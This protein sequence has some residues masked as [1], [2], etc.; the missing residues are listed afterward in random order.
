MSA[1][2]NRVSVW[3][4]AVVY[5]LFLSGNLIAGSNAW[6]ATAPGTIISN[7]AQVE[8]RDITGN[9][10]TVQSNKANLAVR[11]P[12]KIEIM[13]YAPAFAGSEWI[14][15]SATE[16][17]DNAGK[18]WSMPA[19]KPLDATSPLE[20]NKPWP[21]MKADKLY[22]NDT[23]FIRLTDLDQNLDPNKEESVVITLRISA[24]DEAETLRLYESGPNT[25]I[26]MGYIKSES[27]G[28]NSNNG[29]LNYTK[30]NGAKVTSSYVD[31]FDGTD[32]TTDL[33]L[34]VD[35]FGVIF[36]S[37]TGVPVNGVTITLLN[38]STGQPAKV[39]GDDGVSAYPSTMV[40]GTPVTDAGGKVYTFSAGEYRFPLVEPGKYRLAVT[41]PAG[42]KFPS[43][44]ATEVLQKLPGGP[45]VLDDTGSR[46]GEFTVIAGPALRFDIP[47][48]PLIS[49]LFVAKSASKQVASVGDFLQYKIT[50]ENTST[51]VNFP[52]VTVTDVLP[53]G[54]RY[55]KGSLQLNGASV[56]DPGISDDGKTLGINVGGLVVN[57]KKTILYV[58]EVSAGVKTGKS[59]NS[60]QA[61]DNAGTTS[62]TATATV[63]VKDAF[64]SDKGF[65]AGNVVA[66]ACSDGT[67]G[68]GTGVE[69]IRIYLEDGTYVL[70]DKNG[71]YHFEG[72]SP[73]TRVV[74]LDVASVPKNYEVVF[75]EKNTRFADNPYSQFADIRGGTLWRADFYLRSV[76]EGNSSSKTDDT[77]VEVT[78]SETKTMPS[79]DNAWLDAADP[80]F[81][82]LWPP[83]GFYPSMPSIKVTVKH[84]PAKTLK[85]YI[86]QQEVD[87]VY[88]DGVMKRKDGKI[89]ISFW[90]AVNLSEG[91]NIL[92]AVEYHQDGTENARIKRIFHYSGTPVK[93]EILLNQSVLIADGKTPPVI[94]VR[95]TDRD[96]HPAGEGVTGEFSVDSP[97]I[98]LKIADDMQKNP[99]TAVQIGASNFIVGDNGMALI[100]LQPTSKTGEAVL[101]LSLENGVHE[102]RVWLN[103]EKR[104]WIL[105]GVADGTLGYGILTEHLEQLGSLSDSVD[106]WDEDG[107]IAFF[108]KGAIK[109]KWLLTMAYESVK[110]W[111]KDTSSLHQTI[112]P[113]TYYTVYG[114]TSQQ[115]YD[116]A[117]SLPLYIKIERDKFYAL[118]GDYETG[119]TVTELS[120]YNRNF[121]GFK[122]EL[123]EDKYGFNV[124]V[125][126]TRQKYVRDEIRGDGTSGLYQLTKKNIVL[127]SESVTI[128]T[129]DRFHS[130]NILTSRKLTRHTDYNIDYEDATLY[131][132]A[133]VSSKDEDFNPVFIVVEYETGDLSDYNYGGRASFTLLD[134]KLETGF[135]YVHDGKAGGKGDLAGIDAVYNL[136]GQTKLKTEAAAM[137]TVLVSGSG[138]LAELYNR[139]DRFEGKF[140]FREQENDF[141]LGQQKGSESRT[142]KFGM[143]FTY[144]LSRFM[145]VS[146]DAYKSYNL[147]TSAVRTVVGIDTNYSAGK[148]DL[149]AGLLFADDDYANGNEDMS[150]QIVLGSNFRLL[151]DRLN[152]R[153]RHNQSIM[154]DDENTDFPTRTTFGLDY[155]LRNNTTLFGEQEFTWSDQKDTESTRLGV[156]VSPWSGS[157]INST[158][159]R[160]FNENGTRVF[161]V[162]GMKQTW[163]VTKKWTI[164]AGLDRSNTLKDNNPPRFNVNVPETSGGT[165][166]TAVSLGA[167][168]LEK[169]WSWTGRV[170]FK[171]SASE[172]KTGIYTGLYAEPKPGLGTSFGLQV[173][174]TDFAT[175]ATKTDGK[176]SLG[177]AYRPELS[178]WIILDR[179]EYIFEKQRN[180]DFNFD[181]WRLVNNFNAHY[182]AGRK[183]RLA[184]LYGAKFVGET[185]DTTEY[186][187][188]TDLI[189]LEPRYD[190][191]KK[192]DVGIR[193]LMLHSWDANQFKYSHDLSLGYNL[194]KNIWLS[195][196]Y[197]WAGFNDR[198]FSRA[199]FT[200]DGPFFKFRLKFDQRSFKDEAKQLAKADLNAQLNPVEEKAPVVAKELI[201][202]EETKPDI[203]SIA[204]PSNAT[205]EKP[206]NLSEKTINDAN[207]LTV[208]DEKPSK[209]KSEKPSKKKKKSKSKKK[210]YSK[211][212]YR[213]KK[214]S[215]GEIKIQLSD[216]KVK[217]K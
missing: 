116:A 143:D 144:R 209:V 196:G 96:G 114:D 54:F 185:I 44:V 16:Y 58:V 140:Y 24:T 148:Y 91:D 111:K 182:K 72:V 141:G 97:Y 53:T 173:F 42:F 207:P 2:K 31:V 108:A 35:P 34:L 73:G 178:R 37:A 193:S 183:M 30:G 128:E 90:R 171:D 150:K 67:V 163:T 138:Y 47:M 92:E 119:L 121:T 215:Y 5:W 151:K 43:T 168:F 75:C 133:S 6:G 124:F 68:K 104:E 19:P 149:L 164:D 195:I 146:A 100:K 50:V 59:A 199:D 12:S 154:G 69:G 203:V 27:G 32:A 13:E 81:E 18:W 200:N 156:K 29:T 145:G 10:V 66:D 82:L 101:K 180:A 62:N 22:G 94:A 211:K 194:A 127:N 65:I 166:F 152:F 172:D 197:N 137:D 179:L 135:T 84:D 26:F 76:N 1:K 170:E 208:N 201:T 86:N 214:L 39:F 77:K 107:R 41:S 192:W 99:L 110:K 155:K 120:R 79:F 25:G 129:R 202:K 126:D 158:V 3:T 93:A 40:S 89:N 167:S 9:M 7:V 85:L 8:Y 125:A 134:K 38:T 198:D 60:A 71:M 46:G 130:E 57:E 56:A 20:M 51:L 204:L 78:P 28:A 175:G 210:L 103:P 131:F 106:V 55:K 21:L 160:Q 206:E 87:P 17:K 95:L 23:L 61:S 142:K 176:I 159:E 217:K 187:G 122:S 88:Y 83:E 118:F 63:L 113:D 132:R 64:F 216:L 184:M 177:L 112:D 102:F 189:G 15:V 157:E 11:S 117:S 190:L 49:A 162:L 123:K 191:T 115:Q 188:Y 186:K 161:S 174:K 205:E 33:S 136:S 181:N 147:V 80:G 74:Q 70:T 52:G 213:Q 105:V 45:F 48:D 4:G 165:D 98:P 14:K 139:S 153:T 212:K 36:D 109:G 169:M